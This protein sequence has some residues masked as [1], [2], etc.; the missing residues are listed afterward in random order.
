MF[1]ATERPN[2]TYGTAHAQVP[3]EAVNIHANF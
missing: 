1:V 2:D 3:G